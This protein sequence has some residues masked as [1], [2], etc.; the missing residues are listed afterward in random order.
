MIGQIRPIRLIDCYRS[1]KRRLVA[2]GITILVQA[3]SQ[4]SWFSWRWSVAILRHYAIGNRVIVESARRSDGRSIGRPEFCMKCTDRGIVRFS[5][6]TH[7]SAGET[8]LADQ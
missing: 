1:P 4:Y 2:C 8:P 3:A 5:W 6:R 7:H